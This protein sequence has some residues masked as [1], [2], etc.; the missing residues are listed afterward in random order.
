MT[1]STKSNFKFATLPKFSSKKTTLNTALI[2]LKSTKKQNLNKQRILQFNIKTTFRN[3]LNGK[4][5]YQENIKS[6][7]TTHQHMSKCFI[8]E[9]QISQQC[10]SNKAPIT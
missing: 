3:S 9:G 10:S 6:S 5:Q 1:L 2:H 7:I 4:I 8:E